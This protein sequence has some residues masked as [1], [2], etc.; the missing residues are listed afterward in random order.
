M[1]GPSHSRP[2]SMPLSA[3]ENVDR[4]CEDFEA[5]WQAAQSIR[6]R[7]RIE[8]YL[9]T[10]H[11]L[12]RYALLR[13]LLA[14]DIAY[15]IQ[16]KESPEL[17][18]YR[19]RFS[20]HAELVEAVYHAAAHITFP[21]SPSTPL[22]PATS[23]PEPAQQVPEQE[24]AKIAPAVYGN[25]QAQKLTTPTKPE[26][27]APADAP[28]IPEYEVFGLL[29]H[30]GMGV[31]YKARQHGLQRI[32]AL[33]MIR[34]GAH[35]RPEELVRFRREAETVARLQHP[36]IVQIYGVGEYKGQP[37]CAL[38]FIDGGN[39]AAK[40]GGKPQPARAAAQLVET[41]ARTMH[42]THEQ[43]II[44][45]DLKPGNV[46]L[47]AGGTPK[48]TDF[49]LAKHLDDD[50]WKTRSGVIVGTPPYMAPEQARNQRQDIG[51]Q[52]DVYAL[53]AVLYE[54]LTGR[55]PF[56]AATPMD[57]LDQVRNLEPVPPSHLQPKVPRDLETICLKCLE[58]DRQRRY[59]S[60][61]T[62]A[63]DLHRFLAHEPIRARPVRW[64]ERGLK[65]AKRR[66]TIAAL[67]TVSAVALMS[68]L[69]WGLLY[70]ELRARDLEGQLEQSRKVA[71]QKDQFQRSL[72]EGRNNADKQDWTMLRV[73]LD[74]LKNV[75][76]YEPSPEELVDWKQLEGRQTAHQHYQKFTS[77]RD[78]AFL[79][80]A[81]ATGESES[82]NL[83]AT[84]KAVEDALGLFRVHLDGQ[85]SLTLED[86]FTPSEQDD[87]R[88]GCYALLLILAETKAPRPG[89]QLQN[90]APFR[91]R[92]LLS[93]LLILNRVASL[94]DRNHLT[95]A[96]HRI[97]ARILEQ[98]GQK[99][100]A[101]NARDQA[102]KQPPAT[103]LDY[104]LVG[105]EHYKQG[106]MVEAIGDF[107]N[108]LGRQP[109]H[110]WARYFLA[111][112]YLRLQTPRPDLARDLLTHCIEQRHEIIW[113]YF[114]LGYAHTKLK[115][116]PAA[117]AD[118]KG[119]E[120]LLQD[121][122]NKNAWPVFYANRGFL[123]SEQHKFEDA[124]EDL[125]RAITRNSHEYQAHV[126]LA[127]VYQK[128]E[129]W[130]EALE[131]L[132]QAIRSEPRLPILHRLRAQLHL[133]RPDQNLNAALDDYRK[134]IK[135]DEEP[136]KDLKALAEDCAQQG[137]ILHRIGRYK[138]AV[139]AYNQALNADLTYAWAHLWR[140]QAQS[141]LR[142]Y[143]QAV[144]SLGQYLKQRGKPTV[145]VY[146][147]FGFAWA[148]LRQYGKAIDSY[149]LALA[150]QPNDP[151]TLAARGW[152]RL[153][154]ADY[155]L[156]LPDF[157][158]AIRWSPAN[159]T[160]PV[161]EASIVGMVSPL[162]QGPAL[163]VSALVSWRNG[164]A[165]DGRG[166]A[167][168]NLGDY[169]RA[170]EDAETALKRDPHS[171][172]LCY[173]AARIYAQAVKKVSDNPRQL[174]SRLMASNYQGRA[175]RLIRQSLELRPDKERGPFWRDTIAQDPA[176][177][178]IR[179]STD[180]LRLASYYSQWKK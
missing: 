130:D 2:G 122:K 151:A 6:E 180:F 161:S 1:S 76:L 20:E 106:K 101:Q 83:Q 81:L 110:F 33:K 65:W 134:A 68:S 3:E 166:Y 156:A 32:V 63:E 100:A 37:F 123:R 80:A 10:V 59:G 30:G 87:I 131:E 45:R 69:A 36:H 39:L 84:Q 55:P 121:P 155:Q 21:E 60:A 127:K 86:S 62:L 85:A 170:V 23:P 93:A 171:A 175:L 150:M 98:L 112:S 64:W 38:E 47:T 162:A 41:L 117:E 91:E 73:C 99:T 168:V 167:R 108:V 104:Y 105:D 103:A 113:P 42:A 139:K 177:S 51:P 179:A 7:P 144:H 141:Q 19:E 66:P 43:G 56:L 159:G 35:A 40:L 129:R 140:A 29:G 152:A 142:N 126:A 137:R 116:F 17:A 26:E 53:G 79:H 94:D 109:D 163:A 54:M 146:R 149:T 165:Y 132:D 72:R 96:Y 14:L 16:A 172:R 71:E 118:F 75:K 92:A 82:D 160:L 115:N 58:K 15:R 4:V 157:E 61:L 9:C 176:L 13:E 164:D 154:V 90:L 124:A 169:R 44:H 147:L 158:D 5:A 67:I 173:D 178:P 97:H 153:A 34:A 119:A 28:V 77:L 148:Q 8:E 133:E 52:T 24:P 31:V 12:E 107:G 125:R 102:A 174:N 138:A 88:A 27:A 143:E 95:H 111:L 135:L 18:D 114:V 48:I 25:D 57:T 145:E 49:G 78:D 74:N 70:V 50:A 128:Q 89:Q 46:L 11:A 120:I 136:P 22:I